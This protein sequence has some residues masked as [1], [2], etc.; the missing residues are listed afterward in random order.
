[1]FV[2][3]PRV[4]MQDPLA[5]DVEAEVTGLDHARVDRTDGDLIGVAAAN[6]DGPAP[7]GPGRGSTRGEAARGRRSRRRRGHAPRARP[8]RRRERGRRSRAPLPSVTAAC[9]KRRAPPRVS[10]ARIAPPPEVAWRSAKRQPS[11][12]AASIRSRYPVTPVPSGERVDEVASGQPER[13]R[14]QREQQDDRD[15]GERGERL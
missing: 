1:M 13:G 10:S 7:P 11:A 4:E 14:G 9:S 8:T 6:R 5:D 3:E 12:S 15:G 2:E